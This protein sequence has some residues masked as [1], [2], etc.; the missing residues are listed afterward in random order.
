MFE[1]LRYQVANRVA[2]IT[3]HRPEKLN[4]Y[5]T[6]MM[7][8]LVAAFDRSDADDD[9]GCVVLTGEGRAYCAGADLSG[10][11]G[12]FERLA[13]DP[14]RAALRHGD[15]SRDG[16]GVGALRIFDSLKPV[17]AAINGPAVGIGATM[18]LPA[19]IRIASTTAKFGFVF[20]R[21]GIVPEAASSWFLPRIVGISR[22]LEWTM[23]GR[24]VGA[25]EAL[26]AG[27]VRSLHEPDDLMPAAMELAHELAHA[28]APVAVSLT[29]QM[30]WRM[31]GASHPM[32]AHRVDS[33]ALRARGTAPDTREGV[34]AFIDKRD[35]HFAERVSDGLPD[36]WPDPLNTAFY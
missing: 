4:A 14:A 30:M 5:N 35:P 12:A 21:R 8:E 7:T 23:A 27:L 34:Q 32:A 31:L 22:A 9:V 28:G 33:R 36:I 13:D 6:A 20:T 29:R 24:M 3:L 10:G 25:D 17:V 26:A 19:D 16:G 11:K 2:T 18:L 15:L 1:T